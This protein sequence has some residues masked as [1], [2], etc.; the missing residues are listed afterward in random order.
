M[1]IIMVIILCL[2]YSSSMFNGNIAHTVTNN[3][4]IIFS[5]ICLIFYNNTLMNFKEVNLPYRVGYF[6]QWV[7]INQDFWVYHLKRSLFPSFIFY[8]NSE[9][10]ATH[11]ICLILF[12][13]CKD[14]P[15]NIPTAASYCKNTAKIQRLFPSYMHAIIDSQE[16]NAT[17][18]FQ[19]VV[20]LSMSSCSRAH[21]RLFP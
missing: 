17:R 12:S 13:L 21:M 18:C 2:I 15:T 8:P 14:I 6:S 3:L 7:T 4:C 11:L 19:D 20:C 1:Y 10:T 16:K 5:S 9:I